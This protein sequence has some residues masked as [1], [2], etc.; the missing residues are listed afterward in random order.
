M[1][2]HNGIS[3]N[4]AVLMLVAT[5][6]CLSLASCASLDTD[7]QM[8]AYRMQLAGKIGKWTKE[9]VRAAYGD[10]DETTPL[11]SNQDW[12]D[13]GEHWVIRRKAEERKG[14]DILQFDFDGDDYL[15]H[16]HCR[17]ER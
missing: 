4:R 2:R 15:T 7:M 1:M 17:V 5:L 3:N 9:D 16:W 8:M 13:E 10:P 6:I 11:A 12:Q 14:W